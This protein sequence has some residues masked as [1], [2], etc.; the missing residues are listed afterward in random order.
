MKGW[1]SWR[2]STIVGAAWMTCAPGVAPCAGEDSGLTALAAT[3]ERPLFSPARRPPAPVAVVPSTLIR[4]PRRE[5][6]PP[7]IRL[8]GI[9]IGDAEEIAIVQRNQGAKPTNLRIDSMIDGWT[10]VAIHARDIV[11]KLDSR[12]ITLRMV[13]RAARPGASIPSDE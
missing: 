10:V 3:R 13:D 12:T 11:L 1:R 5:T 8:T 4:A 6:P 9:V 7:A 2:V